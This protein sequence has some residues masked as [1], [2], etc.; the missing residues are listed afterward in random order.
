MFIIFIRIT[1]C[2]WSFKHH[3]FLSPLPLYSTPGYWSVP[4]IS[5]FTWLC[6][7]VP[8]AVDTVPITWSWSTSSVERWS[9]VAPFSQHSIQQWTK[10]CSELT[11][12][13]QLNILFSKLVF[14]QNKFLTEIVAAHIHMQYSL[15]DL[16]EFCNISSLFCHP[17]ERVLYLLIG[18][19]VYGSFIEKCPS[20]SD[21]AM[22]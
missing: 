11:R 5:T 15:H 17:S 18:L 22:L 10:N 6:L 16:V 19:V 8:S 3:N 9:C 7:G 14:F 20:I 21:G 13:I 2:V 1:L 12:Y 4:P